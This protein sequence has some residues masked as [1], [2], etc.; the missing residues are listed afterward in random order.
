MQE[1]AVHNEAHQEFVK[2]MFDRALI[3]AIEQGDAKVC[4]ELAKSS[5]QLLDEVIRSNAV[6]A[7]ARSSSLAS[8]R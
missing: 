6:M 8:E 5:N 4:L 3:V 7:F 1:I 2:K